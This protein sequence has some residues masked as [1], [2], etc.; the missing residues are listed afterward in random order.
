MGYRARGGYRALQGR[1][2]DRDLHQHVWRLTVHGP[3][4]V[5]GPAKLTALLDERVFVGVESWFTTRTPSITTPPKPRGLLGPSQV[6]PLRD[7]MRPLAAGR[8][9]GYRLFV[10]LDLDLG[11]AFQHGKLIKPPPLPLKKS[12][13]PNGMVGG[14]GS[15]GCVFFLI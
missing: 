15:R 1:P 4:T 5:G 14:F 12:I 13:H 8:S 9:F 2:R 7:S 11:F 10:V 6:E 3:V